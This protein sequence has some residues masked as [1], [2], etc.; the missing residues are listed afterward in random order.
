MSVTMADI[1][2]VTLTVDPEDSKNQP[3]TDNGPFTWTE[4]SNGT[5]T[6]LQASAD[7][8]QCNVIAG[9]PGTANVTVTDANGLT[10]VEA[11]TVTSSTVTAL[12]LSASSPQDVPPGGTTP[13]P[14][15]SGH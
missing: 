12:G 1:Q 4:D 11:V 6:T 9:T 14:G 5:V 10:G 7:G 15:T 13:P 3:T 2:F 8:T